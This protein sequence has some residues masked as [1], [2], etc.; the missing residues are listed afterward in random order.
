M[1]EKYR[2]KG[3]AFLSVNVIWDKAGP[4]RKFVEDYRLPFP[5]GREQ[6]VRVGENVYGEITLLYG[7]E[8]TPT[9]LFI[10]KSGNLMEQKEG[11]LEEADFDQRINWLLAK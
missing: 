8:A 3:L 5:V 2:N 11:S 10:G 7:V 1:Y 4:A 6:E 9:T